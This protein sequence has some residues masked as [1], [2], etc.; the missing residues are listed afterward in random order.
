MTVLGLSQNAFTGVLQF[1]FGTLSALQRLNVD[2][3]LLTG[4]LPSE[5]GRLGSMWTLSVTQNAFT[6][7]LPSSFGRLSA[8]QGLHA[9][10]NQLTVGI[11]LT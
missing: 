8:L 11:A 2:H 9:D 7:V 5:L 10:D 1:S 6:G 3:N 4:P